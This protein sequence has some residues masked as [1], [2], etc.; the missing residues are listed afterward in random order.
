M[1]DAGGERGRCCAR[2]CFGNFESRANATAVS[3]EQQTRDCSKQISRLSVCKA[4]Q[5]DVY[6]TNFFSRISFTRGESLVCVFHANFVKCAAHR[7]ART[8]TSSEASQGGGVRSPFSGS[9]WP[10]GVVRRPRALDP[11]ACLLPAAPGLEVL[12]TLPLRLRNASLGVPSAAGQATPWRNLTMTLHRH[13]R[14]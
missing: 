11:C 8:S 7:A 13:R 12:R 9:G 14:S 2:R 1:P 6:S 3:A 4:V 10:L 5:R